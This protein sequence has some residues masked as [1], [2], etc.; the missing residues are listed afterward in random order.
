LLV[1]CDQ[2][3]VLYA[4]TVMGPLSDL[5]FAMLL[6]RVGIQ[7]EYRAMEGLCEIVWP[8]IC[9]V[10]L[11]QLEREQ[12]AGEKRLAIRHALG[13]VLGGHCSDLSY[14]HDGHDWR[15]YEETVADLFALVDLVPDYRV[16]DCLLADWS[17]TDVRT[18]VA[19]R[20]PAVRRELD[21]GAGDGADGVAVEAVC[22][23]REC[24]RRKPEVSMR[25]RALWG[26][27]GML[28]WGISVACS[29]PSPVLPA[30]LQGAWVI[31]H[32]SISVTVDGPDATWS[33]TNCPDRF[34]G[35]VVEEGPIV[36]LYR[37]ELDPFSDD[38]TRNELYTFSAFERIDAG[39]SSAFLGKCDNT[40]GSGAVGCSRDAGQTTWK[41]AQ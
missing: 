38:S 10:H 37:W 31:N 9:G 25:L 34:A 5:T 11:V 21:R 28:A 32:C 41:R 16:E 1:S 18:W 40:T 36:R 30:D 13:H 14:S 3:G 17:W 26:V 15:S 8:P 39:L 23:T 24:A 20:D 19:G 22:R 4:D 33:S 27:C 29:D 7:W 35:G 6:A 2:L 12:T